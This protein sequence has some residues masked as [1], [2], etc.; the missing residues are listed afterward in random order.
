VIGQYGLSKNEQ[1]LKEISET[2]RSP[3][4]NESNLRLGRSKLTPE[5]TFSSVLGG[6]VT[7]LREYKGFLI[8][9]SAVPT[10]ASG[11]DV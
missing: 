9:G 5:G 7:R 6:Q 2:R 10:F 8:D 3:H 11:L 1:S 4:H